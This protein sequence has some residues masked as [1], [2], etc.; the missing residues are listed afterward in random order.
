MTTPFQYSL[1]SWGE[2][3]EE[4]R[5]NSKHVG[6]EVATISPAIFDQVGLKP[7]VDTFYSGHVYEERSYYIYVVS[8]KGMEKLKEHGTQFF[9]YTRA[10]KRKGIAH[11]DFNSWIKAE[12][13]RFYTHC[14]ERDQI[15]IQ[16]FIDIIKHEA[17]EV[18]FIFST[19]YEETDDTIYIAHGGCTITNS[20]YFDEGQKAYNRDKHV[21]QSIQKTL[22]DKYGI[23]ANDPAPNG[24][25][26]E[27]V[28][29]NIDFEKNAKLLKD[30]AELQECCDHRN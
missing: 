21:L 26:Q 5:Y 8:D 10:N 18:G 9:Q 20:S 7:N 12:Y 30:Y 2:I 16:Q 3:Q 23:I 22:L 24:T 27:G 28:L 19:D 17:D 1:Y 15:T 14:K 11:C 4:Y 29:L 25:W 13:E 6:T